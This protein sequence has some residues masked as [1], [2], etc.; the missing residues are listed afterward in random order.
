M[1]LLD[2][3]Q[4]MPTAYYP[5]IDGQTERVNQV[6]EQ[7]LRT[8][9]S[10]D[11]KDSIEL[12]PYAEFCYNNTVHNSTKVT[13]FYANYGYNPRHNYPA[14]EVISTVPAGEE[15]ILTLKKL[16]EDTDRKSTRLNSSHVD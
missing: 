9:C 8:Y 6:L 16:S 12:L 7:Y 2:I 15:L 3:S 13:P 10:W 1:H 14:V 4:D 11:H 5:Q